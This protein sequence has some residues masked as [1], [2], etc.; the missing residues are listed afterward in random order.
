MRLQ[1]E[2]LPRSQR[3]PR[4]VSPGS[5]A[6]PRQGRMSYWLHVGFSSQVCEETPWP[7]TQGSLRCPFGL[8]VHLGLC[9]GTQRQSKGR[10]P[11]GDSR[12]RNSN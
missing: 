1:R 11:G 5:T 9:L 4:A 2:L 3:P 6:G 10:R 7:R 8:E 12:D